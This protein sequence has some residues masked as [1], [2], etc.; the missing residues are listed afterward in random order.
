MAYGHYR[1]SG[2][3]RITRYDEALKRLNDTKPIAGNGV[4]AGVIPLGHRNKSQF[5]IRMR[6]DESIACRLYTTDVVVFDKDGT[7][8]LETDGFYTATTTNFISDV[9]GVNARLHANHLVVEL[10]GTYLAEG[11][12]LRHDTSSWGYEVLKA[13]RVVVHNLDRKG[14]NA[15]RKETQEFRKFLSGFMKVKGNHFTEEELYETNV[16]ERGAIS[17]YVWRENTPEVVTRLEEFMGLVK[18]K[19]AENWHSAATWLCVSA[20]YSMHDKYYDPR[21]AVALLDDV[22]IALNPTVLVPKQLEAGVV[23]ADAYKRFEPFVKE[24]WK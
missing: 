11:L 6:A 7:I 24:Y 16:R 8:T 21:C 22:Q 17:L 19:E 20:R 15:L 4:N 9:L 3:R 13:D 18:S 14:M 12:K 2:I 23:R 5:R 1:N 10:N